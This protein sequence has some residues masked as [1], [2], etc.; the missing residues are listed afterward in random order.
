MASER[1]TT[2]PDAVALAFEQALLDGAAEAAART[3]GPVEHRVRLGPRVLRLC[4][5]GRPLAE[6]VGHAFRPLLLPG[7]G[8]ADAELWAW[9]SATSG[10]APPLPDWDLPGDFEGAGRVFTCDL[11]H[12]ELTAADPAA[13][14][15]VVWRADATTPPPGGRAAPFRALFD[16]VVVDGPATLVHAGVVGRG[17]RGVLLAAPG[18]SGKSTTVV[19]CCEAGM[20]TAGDDFVLVEPTADGHLAHAMYATARLAPSSPALASLLDRAPAAV[21]PPEADGKHVVW[22]E[23]AFPGQ[24]QASLDLVALAVPRADHGDAFPSVRPRRGA[25]ALQALA[26]TSLVLTEGRATSLAAMTAL[27]RALPCFEVR[28]TADLAASVAAV[29]SIL[30]GE[31][32]PL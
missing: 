17:G 6:Q 13:R 11:R 8:P 2:A 30:D 14:R 3:G 29:T 9:D 23:R 28:V 5:V 10:V 21:A 24:V 18:G 27:V 4:T 7:S 26:P 31:A 15:A 20:T 12:G 1:R 19:A 22:L 32:R 16:R 25:A